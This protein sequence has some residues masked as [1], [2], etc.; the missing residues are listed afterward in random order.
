MTTVPR[1][2]GQMR[3][4]SVAAACLVSACVRHLPPAPIPA[5]IRP[6]VATT[7]VAPGR[8]RLVVDVV[9]GRGPVHRVWMRSTRV[10][11]S[12]GRVSF[13]FEEQPEVICAQPPC[14]LD[15]APGNLLLGY[16]V[17]GRANALEVEL[18]HV[19]PD[20]SVY[21]RSLSEFD[22]RSGALQTLGIVG[23]S[24]GGAGLLTGAVLLPIGLAGGRDAMSMAGG[25]TLGAGAA[26]LALGIW[27]MRHDADTFRPGSANH[28]VMTPV[29][30]AATAP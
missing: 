17:L 18:V 8:A 22:D 25:V 2:A 29:G 7:Q 30:N 4:G 21:R 27:A 1:F 19:G 20:P 16:P 11:G 3:A 14:S 5:A 26:L 28:Y 9:D 12:Q 24:T 15:V 23:A 6:P 13:R 10:D